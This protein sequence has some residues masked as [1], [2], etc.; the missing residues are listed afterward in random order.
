M[1]HRIRK[2]EL[3]WMEKNWVEFRVC[4]RGVMRE[5]PKKPW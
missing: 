1:D 2:K 4:Q 5:D 3:K